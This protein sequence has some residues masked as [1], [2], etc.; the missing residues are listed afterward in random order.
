MSNP[1]RYT[2]APVTKKDAK[3]AAKAMLKHDIPFATLNSTDEKP[4][5]YLAN[6]TPEHALRTEGFLVWGDRFNLIC[7]IRKVLR[8]KE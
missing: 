1:D 7:R 3:R 8:G 5:R 2:V 4:K 6:S